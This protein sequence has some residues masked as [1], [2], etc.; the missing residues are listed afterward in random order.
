MSRV[1]AIKERQ[2]KTQI[3]TALAEETGLT[4]KEVQTVLRATKDLAARHLTAQG[5]GDFSVP[6]LGVKLVRA[7]RPARKAGM[8]RN[9]F[10]GEMVK[11]EARPAS[12]SVR[13][14]ALKALKD[15]VA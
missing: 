13:A 9:P 7:Q 2:T 4:K 14:R 6:E 10:T 15:V 12:L 8:A 5:S 1:R 3:L 11:V